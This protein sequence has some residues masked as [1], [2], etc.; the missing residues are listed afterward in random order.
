MLNT[1]ITNQLSGRLPVLPTAVGGTGREGKEREEKENPNTHFVQ[2]MQRGK[3][4]EVV[5]NLF[6]DWLIVSLAAAYT[7]FTYV[8]IIFASY[9][10]LAT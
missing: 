4:W 8:S 10:Q 2:L 7:K 1:Q 5:G 9:T 6:F 3:G